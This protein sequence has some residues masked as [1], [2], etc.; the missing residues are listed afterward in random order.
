MKVFDYSIL[1]DRTW[2]NEIVSYLA[3]IH[4][5]KGK[6]ELYIRQKPVE[7]ER[8]IEIARIQSTE[9]SN[10]IEGIVTT[11]ARLKQL[12]ENKTTKEI[13][14]ILNISEKTVRNHISNTMQK[15][16]VKGRAQAVVELLRLGEITL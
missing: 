10:R 13:A 6:Q 1:S 5:Y 12:V 8:L 3:Q 16:S 4:E 11:H 7:L 15:L 9:A 2:D 14:D